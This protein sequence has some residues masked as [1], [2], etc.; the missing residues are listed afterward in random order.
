[1]SLIG[2]LP[3]GLEEGLKP[4][5]ILVINWEHCKK[6]ALHYSHIK[7]KIFVLQQHLILEA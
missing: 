5:G 4:G 3:S 1:M 7:Q 6:D 2:C